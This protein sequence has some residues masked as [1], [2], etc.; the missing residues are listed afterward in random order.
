[1]I[2]LVCFFTFERRVFQLHLVFNYQSI[3]IANA[4]A[5]SLLLL[6]SRP[7][8]ENIIVQFLF[9]SDKVILLHLIRS[10]SAH[11]VVFAL[12]L[13]PPILC[14][15]SIIRHAQ[16]VSVR[17]VT[18][19]ENLFFQPDPKCFFSILSSLARMLKKQ[20]GQLSHSQ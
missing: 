13:A 20:L 18:F 16:D 15:R 5:L 1:M 7:I 12:K 2:F 3:L 19:N 4:D 9:I 11:Q 8:V 14:C 6:V 17:G 10:F